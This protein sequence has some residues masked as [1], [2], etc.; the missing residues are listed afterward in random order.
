MRTREP[1]APVFVCGIW[2]ISG[3]IIIMNINKW[4]GYLLEELKQNNSKLKNDEHGEYLEIPLDADLQKKLVDLEQKPNGSFIQIDPVKYLE[5]LYPESLFPG[6]WRALWK[7]AQDIRKKYKMPNIKTRTKPIK[8][9]KD[10]R[11]KND[12]GAYFAAE[13]AIKINFAFAKQE[14][15]KIYDIIVHEIGHMLLEGP[16]SAR[17]SK[18]TNVHK[19][20]L[21][22]SPGYA[23]MS[24]IGEI[25]FREMVN[26]ITEE[27][28]KENTKEI[29]KDKKILMAVN[30]NF[31]FSESEQR[32][33][34]P[35]KF[36]FAELYQKIKQK[37]PTLKINFGD[38]NDYIKLLDIGDSLKLTDYKSLINKMTSKVNWQVINL[39]IESLI[40]NCYTDKTRKC[41]LRNTEIYKEVIST[42]KAPSNKAYV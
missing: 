16:D 24:I 39:A 31:S 23:S 35:I 29:F 25:I 42:V 10:N 5:A 4:Y 7:Q 28:G 17:I 41:L 38:E 13:D 20:Y 2:I 30:Y 6:G 9:I 19:G 36:W 11:L 12:F 32:Y 37:D 26:K 18:E 1:S 27:K 15:V 21:K 34:R 14:N 22:P 33:Y 8:I 3:L 40:T